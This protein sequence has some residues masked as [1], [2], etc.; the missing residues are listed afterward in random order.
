MAKVKRL[1]WVAA[2]GL[3]ACN[4]NMDAPLDIG[5][6][7]NVVSVPPTI[8]SDAPVITASEPP[9]PLS[10]GSL[11]VGPNGA[12]VVAADPDRDLVHVLRRD[13]PRLSL[14]RSVEFEGA[15]PGRVL[16]APPYAFVAL[17]STGRIARIELES[18][19]VLDRPTCVEPRGL[20]QHEGAVLVACASGALRSHDQ[21]SLESIDELPVPVDARDVVVADGVILVSQF[22]S[23]DVFRVDLEARTVAAL[24][25]PMQGLDSTTVAYRM[26]AR[27]QQVA[28]LHQLAS[29]QEIGVQEGGYGGSMFSGV[30]GCGESIVAPA[31][32]RF[33]VHQPE[34]AAITH[35]RG[36]LSVDV[37]A[38]GEQFAVAH[39]GTVGRV[40]GTEVVNG[41]PAGSC[42][43]PVNDGLFGSPAS[44]AA[45]RIEGPPA[46]SVAFAPDGELLMLHREPSRLTSSRTTESVSLSARS[47]A[48]SGFD[49]FHAT[50]FGGVSCASCHPEGGD[51]GHVWNFQAIGPRRTQTL[52]GGILGTEPFHWDGDM[53]D[54]GHLTGDVFASRMS[55]G[56]MPRRHVEALA[57]WMDSIP[58]LAP[59]PVQEPDAIALGRQAFVKADCASCH[60]DAR[61]TGPGSFDVGTGGF[62]QVPPLQGL[63]YRLPLM[64]DGCADSIRS[65]LTDPACGG[66]RA[67]GDLDVLDGTEVLHLEAYLAA[68]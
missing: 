10:G 59:P 31:V 68:Q 66:G 15:E 54:L 42:G 35:L 26:R 50:T 60:S 6:A 3:T 67:H 58:A 21:D 43:R 57:R 56:S 64:H 39:A 37:D 27:G 46:T 12:W 49:A 24:P 5:S 52:R 8:A 18:G 33:E 9:P 25:L 1:R 17:R 36:A 16:V 51:D 44:S 30:V 23:A 47:V 20:A 41:S 53:T 2:A 45:S 62:F 32:L 65:R 7:F 34:S 55:G 48:D 38:M 11:E 63:S 61:G 19:E 22:R 4:V 13:V 40:L 14:V 28:V 29:T